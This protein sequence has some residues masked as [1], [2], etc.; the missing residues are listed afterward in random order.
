MAFNCHPDR[1]KDNDDKM[2]AVNN[3]KDV[4]Q[5]WLKTTAQYANV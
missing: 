2:K 4:L 1:T 5:D 3:A